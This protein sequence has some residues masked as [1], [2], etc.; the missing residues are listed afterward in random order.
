MPLSMPT[1][2]LCWDL[3][4]CENG[5]KSANVGRNVCVCNRSI[6]NAKRNRCL[7]IM[8]GNLMKFLLRKT[9]VIARHYRT[10]KKVTHI[11]RSM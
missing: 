1:F 3:G 9:E 5:G 2:I 7:R 11:L 6:R 8:T 4:Q 10:L